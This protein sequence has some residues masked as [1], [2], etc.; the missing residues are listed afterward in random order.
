MKQIAVKLVCR[1]LLGYC[2]SLS[3]STFLSFALLLMWWLA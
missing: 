2:L 3:V 1:T